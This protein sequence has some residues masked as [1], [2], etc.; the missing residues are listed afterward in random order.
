MLGYQQ[1]ELNLMK[2]FE[3][4]TVAFSRKSDRELKNA[5]LVFKLI[6]FPYLIKLGGI[7]AKFAIKMKLPVAWILKPTVFKVFC[8]GETLDES[9]FVIQRLAKDG[10]GSIL[11]YSA[12]GKK[13]ESGFDDI[14]NEI[15]KTIQFAQNNESIPF[16]VFK[17]SGIGESLILEK[18]SEGKLFDEKEIEIWENIRLRFENICHT[19]F[20]CKVKIL[21]DAEESWIQ[22]AIDHLA[23]EMMLRYNGREAII[24]NTI[25]L[26]RKDRISYLMASFNKAIKLGYFLGVKLVR[27]AYMEKEAARALKLGYKNPIHST[28]EA[29]DYDF[30]SALKFCMGHIETISLCAGTHNEASNRLLAK[31]MENRQIT[32]NDLRVWF[33]QLLGMGDN[34]SYNLARHQYNVAKYIPYGPVKEVLPYLIRRAEENSSV[35]GHASRELILI[36]QELKR[37]K[38]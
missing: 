9:K 15:I 6:S 18:Q 21:I 26:Y 1:L 36:E 28:K 34:I 32:T 10:I 7:A 12:E 16:C 20:E 29:T 8:G 30:N 11:D 2:L 38:K 13:S 25:Q 14:K 24:F 17:T 31:L 22:P 27:G 33:A 3:D 4:S 37:R 19:A 23:E 35:N 5:F